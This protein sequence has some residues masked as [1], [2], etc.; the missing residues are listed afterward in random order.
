MV[1]SRRQKSKGGKK[2]ASEALK[3]SE[4]VIAPEEPKESEVVVAAEETVPEVSQE[5]HVNVNEYND[6]DLP[7][8]HRK[9]P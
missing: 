8:A 1:Y 3:H 4:P 2:L 5:I 6:L 7:I 9:Q